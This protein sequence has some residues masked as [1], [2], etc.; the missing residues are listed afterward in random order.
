MRSDIATTQ[1]TAEEIVTKEK[2]DEDLRQVL[3]DA[4]STLRLLE[5]EVAFNQTLTT[6]LKQILEIRQEIRQTRE[7]I[8]RSNLPEA[9]NLILQ[10]DMHLES[11][12]STR[13]IKAVAMLQLEASELRHTIVEALTRSWQDSIQ[14]D[15]Q[16]FAVSIPNGPT[17]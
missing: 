15:T 11:I 16:N 7:L 3:H 2:R 10:I 6:T 9:V 1:K 8:D 14:I 4:G 13:S 17:C 5:E 12:R